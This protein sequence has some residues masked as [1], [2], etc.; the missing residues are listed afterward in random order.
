MTGD[1]RTQFKLMLPVAL[2]ERLENFAH[3][4]R[5]S[6]SA[7]IIAR[8]ET[9]LERFGPYNASGMDALVKR[10]EVTIEATETLAHKLAYELRTAGGAIGRKD[11]ILSAAIERYAAEHS[12]NKAAAIQSILEDW[13]ENHGL[14]PLVQ[15]DD[16]EPN[17]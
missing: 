12:M 11:E 4:N 17:D 8:L 14:L 6:V 15:N 10:L 16:G 9:S 3:E 5:R 7:E 13:L 1:A 2:K